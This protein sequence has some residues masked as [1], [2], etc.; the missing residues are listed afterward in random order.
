MIPKETTFFLLTI[1][2][3]EKVFLLW[4]N[5]YKQVV[6]EFSE[7]MQFNTAQYLTV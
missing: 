1:L 7:F 4:Q 3:F 2:R 6:W 5:E